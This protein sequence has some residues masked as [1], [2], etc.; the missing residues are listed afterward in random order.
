VSAIPYPTPKPFTHDGADNLI[1]AIGAGA[2]TTVR[3]YRLD[4]FPAS[5]TRVKRL[6]RDG[7]GTLGGLWGIVRNDREE[8]DPRVPNGVQV[9]TLQINDE[10]R[11]VGTFAVSRTEMTSRRPQ[12][13]ICCGWGSRSDWW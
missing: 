9:C 7:S 11:T 2:G 8:R 4:I 5:V 3:S 12:L 6:D 13:R 1:F 10:E